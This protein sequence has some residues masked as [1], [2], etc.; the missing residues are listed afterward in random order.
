MHR[1]GTAPSVRLPGR[2]MVFWLL[3]APL[4]FLALGQALYLV[5]ALALGAV[6]R[7]VSAPPWLELATGLAL[8]TW[9]AGAAAWLVWLAWKGWSR[10]PRAGQ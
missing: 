8:W 6:F 4:M 2:V 10:P 5:P 7:W 3:L 1:R 9:A